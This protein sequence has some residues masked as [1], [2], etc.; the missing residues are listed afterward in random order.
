MK[1]MFDWRKKWDILFDLHKEIPGPR[2][3]KVCGLN[4]YQVANY[5]DIAGEKIANVSFV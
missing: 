5:D 2:I 1:N 3:L 4:F